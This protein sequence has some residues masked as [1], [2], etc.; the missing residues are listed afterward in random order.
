M[1]IVEVGFK[2]ESTL[3]VY[4]EMLKQ[5]RLENCFN[6]QTHD[7]YYTD[8]NLEGL[9]ENEMKQACIRIRVVDNSNYEVQNVKPFKKLKNINLSSNLKNTEKILN[10]YGFYKIFDTLKKDHHYGNDS[11]N[12]RIQLQE[13]E[14]VGLLV[15]YDNS[16]YYNLPLE[17]QRNKLIDILNSYGFKFKYSD[18]GLDKLRTLYYKREMYS[19]NQNG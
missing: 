6:C 7:I 13:I 4:D 10:D 1:Y 5:H 19:K 17:E 8:R 18:L 12:G 9:T 16:D 11:L 15:Y 3:K 14:N 2:L